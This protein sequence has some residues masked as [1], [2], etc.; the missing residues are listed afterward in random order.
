MQVI[1]SKYDDSMIYQFFRFIKRALCCCCSDESGYKWSFERAP[2]PTDVFWENLSVS[3]LRRARNVIVT[4]LA[5][6]LVIGCCFGVIYGINY[7]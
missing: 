3:A 5:T 4:Y 1:L 2:E 7:S 6:L